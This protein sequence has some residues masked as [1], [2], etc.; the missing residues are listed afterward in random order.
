MAAGVFST[1]IYNTPYGTSPASTTFHVT[2]TITSDI[3]PTLQ[4]EGCMFLGWYLSSTFESDTKVNVGETFYNDHNLDEWTETI[5]LYARWI[6]KEYLIQGQTLINLSDEIR[7]LVEISDF[8]SPEGMRQTIENIP[9]QQAITY[10]PLTTEIMAV[11]KG[12]YT[13]GEVIID[14]VPFVDLENDTG[15]EA[16]I[17][18]GDTYADSETVYNKVTFYETILMNL[19]QDTIGE[20]NILSGY[21][22]HDK[23]GALVYGAIT[24][25]R[26]E[27]F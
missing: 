13:K 5:T 4:E 19:T 25:A 2:Q 24:D 17:G 16:V 8:L 15:V 20:N 9:L 7:E 6:D 21:Y 1:I 14:P 23:T 27:L 12:M 18:L 11:P 22:G 10:T 3:I 26:E